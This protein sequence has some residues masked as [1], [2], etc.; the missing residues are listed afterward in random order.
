MAKACKCDRC[1]T[2][3]EV[4]EIYWTKYSVQ[5]NTFGIPSSVDLDL[6][7]NCMNKLSKF[8]KC[9]TDDRYVWILKYVN[10]LDEIDSICGVFESEE[11][12]KAAIEADLENYDESVREERRP[13]FEIIKLRVK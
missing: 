4:S 13:Y 7:P 12:A 10:G 1:G 2:F 9:E 8:M 3:Y 5:E 11:K 6:C